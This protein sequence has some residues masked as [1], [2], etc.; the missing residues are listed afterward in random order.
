MIIFGDI[1]VVGKRIIVKSSVRSERQQVIV[2]SRRDSLL[3]WTACNSTAPYLWRYL[4][5]SYQY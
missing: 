4:V 3:V 5:Q 1:I 2:Y